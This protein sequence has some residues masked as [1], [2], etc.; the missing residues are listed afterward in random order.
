MVDRG[1]AGDCRF[2]V[3]GREPEPFAFRNAPGP[4]TAG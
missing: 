1:S 4:R 3:P 2:V